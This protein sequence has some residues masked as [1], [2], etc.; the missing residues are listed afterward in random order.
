M[1]KLSVIKK[2]LFN[3]KLRMLLGG[4]AK[5]NIGI[6]PTLSQYGINLRDFTKYFESN[7]FFVKEGFEVSCVFSVDN[8]KIVNFNLFE[9][10]SS[11]YIKKFFLYKDI[12]LLEKKDLFKLIYEL[13]KIKSNKRSNRHVSLKSISKSQ[14]SILNS[15]SSGDMSSSFKNFLY[16]E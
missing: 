14:M 12:D 16:V 6:A 4:S 3:I 5:K 8:G 7:S 2:K 13:S 9:P 15:Y 1:V 11:F 10:S